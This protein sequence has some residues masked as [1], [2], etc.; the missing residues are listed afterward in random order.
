MEKKIFVF[1]SSISWGAWDKEGGWVAR[2]KKLVNQRVIETNEKY[3]GMVYNQ[4]IS[5]DTSSGIVERFEREIKP[6]LWE[7]EEVFIVFEIG[8]NDSM[9]INEKKEFQVPLAVFGSNIDV[10][11]KKSKQFAHKIFFMGATPVIDKILDPIP[12]FLSG[13]YLTKNIG[14]FNKV[15]FDKCKKH[16]IGYIDIFSEF[17]KGKLVDLVSP[18]GVHLS[19]KGHEAVYG[20]AMPV[21]KKAGA[22][23]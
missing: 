22:L 2:F 12:W 5:G 4:S 19:T 6:R 16:E 14:K 3:W 23:D 11:V 15:L 20:L 21:L 18:D 8:I 10:L 7:N 1:G 13:S 17:K 9:Y